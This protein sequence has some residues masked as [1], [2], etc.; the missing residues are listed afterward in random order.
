ME[1]TALVALGR[2]ERLFGNR[3]SGERI[4]AELEAEAR[5]RGYLALAE[6][7]HR[8]RTEPDPLLPG[9]VGTASRESNSL[10]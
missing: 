2:L 9:G 1:S 10:G 4:L 7:I 8:S 6:S 5:D 3:E